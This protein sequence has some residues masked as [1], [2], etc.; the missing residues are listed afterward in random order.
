MLSGAGFSGFKGF[1]RV[2]LYQQ[3]VADHGQAGAGGDDGGH[4]HGG[5]VVQGSDDGTGN[6]GGGHLD[7]AEQG[8]GGAGHGGEVGQGAGHA[9]GQYQAGT[10]HENGLGNHHRPRAVNLLVGQERHDG[11]AGQSGDQTVEQDL[12]R[13][14]VTRQSDGAQITSDVA[15][16]DG[17]EVE[18]EVLGLNPQYVNQHEGG[19]RQEGKQPAVDGGVGQ[20]VAN[21][22][23]VG[24]DAPVVGEQVAQAQGLAILRFQWLGDAKGGD[25]GHDQGV[26]AHGDED[27]VPAE[28][29][30]HQAAQ[31]RGHGR[32]QGHDAGQQGEDFGGFLG[33]IDVADDGATQYRASGAAQG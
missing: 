23:G 13:P 32:C 31:G 12:I 4:H 3:Q 19:A 33:G 20:S 16:H 5:A 28:T 9:L 11:A 14:Q 30:D 26:A 25:R 27:P 29:A 15:H 21:E 22:A 6:G 7:E 18:A 8:R 24:A 2:A 1:R 10:G 17:G